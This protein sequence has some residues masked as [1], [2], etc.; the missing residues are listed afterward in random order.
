[1]GDKMNTEYKKEFLINALYFIT[2][3]GA[4]VFALRYMPPYIFPFIIGVIIAFAVQKPAKIIS[5]RFSV[6]KQYGA[7][8]LTIIICILFFAGISLMLWALG[9][10]LIGL[11]GY[12]P[13]LFSEIENSLLGL[14]DIAFKKMHTL[15]EAQKSN[16]EN[17]I[18]K[19]ASSVL[20]SATDFISSVATA[21]IKGLPTFLVTGV[22][23]VVASCYIAKDFDRLKKFVL[24]VFP[25]GK[26]EKI[27]K[28]KNILH[29]N[30]Y[31]LIKGYT[32]LSLIT[33]VQ[34]IIAFIILGV[35]NP[36][37]IAFVV[38][39][40][41]ALP[42]LGVGTVLI[43]WSIIEFLGQKYFLGLGLLISYCIIL[44]VR[45]FTEPK[46]I[47]AQMGINPIF[48]LVAMF[49]GLKIAGIMGMLA[50]PL[51]LTVIVEYYR[52]AAQ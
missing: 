23:T 19:A 18:T 39:L 21:M 40:V 47:G 38:A 33:F 2:I 41:D 42:I 1:M 46:I 44:I 14:R 15:T 50:L 22:V 36:V 5:D 34:L 35:K 24:G 48:T 8:F 51:S 6:K 3:I 37:L 32:I 45:N 52:N 9:N 30:T 29:K 25:T 17:V 49:L 4:V 10:R 20:L 13:K 11:M 12:M 7:V 16:I 31:K 43:P 27:V 26:S 28:L